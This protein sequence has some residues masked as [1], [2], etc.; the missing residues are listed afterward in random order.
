[1]LFITQDKNIRGC[2]EEC[3]LGEAARLFMTRAVNPITNQNQQQKINFGLSFANHVICLILLL[4]EVSLP[5]QLFFLLNKD[6]NCTSYHADFTNIF[7]FCWQKDV[8]AQLDTIF[9][10]I[11]GYMYMN[12]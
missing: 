8:Y 3:A 7:Y 4:F 10:K 6:L 2:N 9:H 1:M 12:M 5:N 11:Y